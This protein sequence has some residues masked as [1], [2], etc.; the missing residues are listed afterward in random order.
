MIVSAENTDEDTLM[1][2]A[3]DAGAEDVVNE[4][5]TFSVLTESSAFNDVHESLRENYKI[6]HADIE[7]M[8]GTTVRIGDVGRC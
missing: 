4:G 5:E 2:T 1:L 3:L 7:M 6:E 8:P